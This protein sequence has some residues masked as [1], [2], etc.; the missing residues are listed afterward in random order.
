LPKVMLVGSCKSRMEVFFNNLAPDSGVADKLLHDLSLAEEGAEE[1][2][3]AE[4]DKLTEQTRERFLTGIER[5]KA[6]C[7][8]M[9]SRAVSGAKAADRAV[10]EHPYSVA[11][12]A[13]GLGLLIGALV[14]RAS[15][16]T[17]DSEEE[18]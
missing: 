11:G 15:G 14:W 12:V 8:D 13:F 2:F 9:Q 10:R 16:I 7:R 18:Y 1:L 3:E 17:D 5:V 4:G 6:A